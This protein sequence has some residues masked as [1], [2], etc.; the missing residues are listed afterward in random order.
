MLNRAVSILVALALA[1]ATGCSF[2]MGGLG[3]TSTLPTGIT[4]KPLQTRV[5]GTDCA[6][7]AL[8]LIPLDRMAPSVEAAMERALAEAPEADL[9]AD[10]TI[11]SR[12]WTA[13]LVGRNCLTVRGSAWKAD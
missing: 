13:I 11:Q 2:S 9:L 1:G 8:V 4:G 10:V 7:H 6:W 5:E 12:S 3:L